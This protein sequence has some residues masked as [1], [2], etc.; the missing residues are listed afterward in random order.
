MIA[1][2]NFDPCYS[3]KIKRQNLAAALKHPDFTLIEGDI[4]KERDLERIKSPIDSIVHLAAKAGVRPSIENPVEYMRVNV[5]GTA[6]L[7][8]F[9]RKRGITKFVFASS[10]SVYGEK[11]DRPWSESIGDLNPIS[12]YAVSK[13]AAEK[14]GYVHSRLNGLDFVALRLFSVYGER[15]RPDLAL[16]KFAKLIR[17][18]KVIEVYGSTKTARDYTYVGDVV[19]YIYRALLQKNSG[20]EVFNVGCGRPYSIMKLISTLALQ[21][22]ME[23]KIV[24]TPAKQGDVPSTWAS[25]KKT[26]EI[27]GRITRTSISL[28]MARF[29]GKKKQ[30]RR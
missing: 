5:S 18:R 23:Y 26:D 15:Q 9:A 3:K 24:V 8:E 7:L 28:G 22:G 14:L 11:K 30:I 2:D 19:E 27:L 20:Y 13:L 1:L 6:N 21:L 17:R 10:S 29:L 4:T 16:S 25:N 12:H